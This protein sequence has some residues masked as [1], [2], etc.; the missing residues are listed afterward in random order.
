MNE[1][2]RW[3]VICLVG[4]VPAVFWPAVGSWEEPKFL[5]LLMAVFL[6]LPEVTKSVQYRDTRHVVVL[7]F[8]A[9]FALSSWRGWSSSTI[10]GGLWIDGLAGFV[11]LSML[12]LATPHFP[13]V[14]ILDALLWGTSIAC[15]YA[16]LQ[17]AGLD[18]IRWQIGASFHNQNL[19]FRTFG[20]LGSP[21]L[22][23]LQASL[24]LPY[25]IVRA[26][27]QKWMTGVCLVL[28]AGI[29]CT[30]SRASECAAVV[31]LIA[32]FLIWSA[33]RRT[34]AALS[35]V[36]IFLFVFPFSG[37][38][39]SSRFLLTFDPE[40]SG[41]VRIRLWTLA[42]QDF[43]QHPIVG[44]GPGSAGKVI[45]LTSR[46]FVPNNPSFHNFVL[47]LAVTA[48]A[49]GLFAFVFA[50]TQFPLAKL[51]TSPEM[52]A[53]LG[54]GLL[55]GAIHLFVGFATVAGWVTLT[56]LASLAYAVPKISITPGQPRLGRVQHG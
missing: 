5:V 21:S 10:L 18:P 28:L 8:G 40:A 49:L 7:L 17:V 15:L 51:R 3:G 23:G 36:A 43:Q 32:S 48:G 11:L 52:S 19:S 26:S 14:R 25:A 24:L 34:I 6:M 37:R 29:A 33:A 41:Y 55:S 35:A 20:T 2:R 4:A 27:S 54:L 16:V 1:L 13:S 12:F 42:L 45:G 9:S 44:W 31:A 39:A 30:A 47:D 46:G 56:V 53:A 50:L 22:L 38:S